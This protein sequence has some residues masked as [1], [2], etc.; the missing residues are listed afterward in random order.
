MLLQ[1]QLLLQPQL[2]LPL[3]LLLWL[4]VA[5]AAA[6]V[7]SL[8]AFTLALL[9]NFRREAAPNVQLMFRNKIP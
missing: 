7:A 2:C 9:A 1:L 6:A 5:V 8:V 4:W 3:Y